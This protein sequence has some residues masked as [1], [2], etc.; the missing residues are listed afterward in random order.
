[1][2]QQQ[3]LIV[4]GLD[5]G[6]FKIIN[7]LIKQN[8]LPNLKKLLNKSSYGIL[9]GIIPPITPTSWETAV[10][11]VNP[12]KHNIFDF[13]NYESNYS[14]SVLS[15]KDRKAMAVWDYMAK[16]GKRSIIFNYPMGYPPPEI[17]GIFV[18][19][20]NTPGVNTEFTFPKKI[21]REILKKVPDYQIDVLSDYIVNNNKELFFEECK[22]ITIGHYRAFSYLIRKYKWNLAMFFL[23]MSDRIHHYFFNDEEKLAEYYQLIDFIVG[24]IQKYY[25]KVSFLIF[26]DHGMNKVEKDVYIEE[27]LKD[28]KFLILENNRR[29][30]KI[31]FFLAKI[32]K[33]GRKIAYNLK[34]SDKLLNFLPGWLFNF[35]IKL[36]DTDRINSGI[37]WLKTKAY[38]P[39]PSS[40]GI[41]VNLLGREKYGCVLPLKYDKVRNDLIKKILEMKDPENG[42]KIVE[43]VYKREDL[44]CG[45]YIDNA[46]DLI[47]KTKPAYHLQKGLSKG[48]ISLAAKGEIPREADHAQEGIFILK[49]K[50]IKHKKIRNIKLK[51]M[52]AFILYCLHIPKDKKI[53]GKINSNIFTKTK[54]R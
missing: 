37:D 54:G 53:E 27:Y 36:A 39:A 14:I 2:K 11:G 30:K 3:K 43:K 41:R 40:Q 9:K 49:N 38:F 48:K 31:N 21:K 47:I 42:D 17:K 24:E 20:M 13:F 32:I 34:I 12:G 18:S 23:T 16:T 22:R 7:P 33:S 15:S 35:F 1:M 50:G 6:T 5:G 28:W 10:T 29:E 51:D 46:Q 8:K 25:P 19:G 44:Y 52:A 26:S 45:P 4:L